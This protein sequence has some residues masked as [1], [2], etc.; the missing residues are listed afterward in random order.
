MILF[1]SEWKTILL[2]MHSNCQNMHS[3]LFFQYIEQ[4]HFQRNYSQLLRQKI[5]SFSTNV[6]DLQN[7]ETTERG[8]QLHWSRCLKHSAKQNK[9]KKGKQKI[10]L[11]RIRFYLLRL[12]H[13]FEHG[14]HFAFY[15]EILEQTCHG[16]GVVSWARNWGLALKALHVLIP[17]EKVLL[18][19][20]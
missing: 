17:L 12:A 10:Q 4:N 9:T 7:S 1:F 13:K 5:P 19:L 3:L 15:L 2:K 20:I 18:L 16:V 6:T 8:E 14:F 11:Q